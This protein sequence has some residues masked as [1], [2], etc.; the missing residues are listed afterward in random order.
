MLGH[1]TIYST[2]TPHAACWWGIS[3][4]HTHV[5]TKDRAAPG[6]WA[7]VKVSPS[8]GHLFMPCRSCGLWAVQVLWTHLNLWKHLE[9]FLYSLR[10]SWFLKKIGPTIYFLGQVRPDVNSL[11][12]ESSSRH[13]R[14]SAMPDQL[15][16]EGLERALTYS[17]SKNSKA[18][19]QG[20]LPRWTFS[21]N[22]CFT[23]YKTQIVK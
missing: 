19:H 3:S 12:W 6:S 17:A 1:Q 8:L 2:P 22:S 13:T 16:R 14:T 10:T 15:I 7:D 20:G 5:N 23:S 18:K 9:L 4:P 11:V 21:N